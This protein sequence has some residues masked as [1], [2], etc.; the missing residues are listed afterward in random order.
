MNRAVLIS[1]VG[2]RQK[3]K[4][5]R[6]AA[7]LPFAVVMKVAAR[8]SLSTVVLVEHL[9]YES[10]VIVD[11]DHAVPVPADLPLPD[12]AAVR[13]YDEPLAVRVHSLLVCQRAP[14]TE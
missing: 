10:I 4:V 6:V 1:V 3:P 12:P 13:R 5:I 14:S 9:M 2:D 11:R 7:R 8:R